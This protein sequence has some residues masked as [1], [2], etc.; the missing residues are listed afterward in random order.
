LAS[1]IIFDIR[2]GEAFLFLTIL[3]FVMMGWATRAFQKAI[4]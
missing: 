1:G 3:A 4:A 2:V